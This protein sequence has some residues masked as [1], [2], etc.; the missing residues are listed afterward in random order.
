VLTDSEL[1]TAGEAGIAVWAGR[2]VLDAQSPVDDETLA[3][4]AERCAGP[5]PAP[6][7]DLWRV[8]FGGRLD[9]QLD[10]PVSL[11]ELFYP[12]SDGYRDLWGW[13]DHETELAAEHQPDWPGRLTHLPIGGFE[14]LD[15]VYLQ[16]AAGP[17]HGGVVYWQ[18]GLPPG[19]ELTADDRAGLLADSLTSLFDRLAL[20]QDPWEVDEADTGDAM[21]DAIDSL[22]E[23]SDPH[24]RS[25]AGKLRRMVRDTV[26]DWRGAL[27]AGTLVAQRRLRR[28]ALD[29]AASAGD[30]VLLDRLVALGCDPAE[31]VRNGLTPIDLA[32]LAG[33]TGTARHLLAKG[34]PV[35]NALR[36]GAHAVDLPLAR[37]LLDRGAAVDAS[38]VQRATGNPDAAVVRLL[39]HAV[40]SS[41]DLAPHFRMLAAAADAAAGRAQAAGH[42]ETA[43]REARRAEIF[44]EIAATMRG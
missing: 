39:A 4:V 9:Y 33:A 25:A 1:L 22:A 36:V 31:E 35:A 10:S 40:P 3:A 26:L 13:I 38:A 18:Q 7:V 44:R 34:V 30:L 20:E 32:L 43:A 41:P 17:G 8:T 2:L 5:L 6:L 28:L 11:A 37:D 21:R 12:D 29:H 15:R 27:Q 16:T 24:A 42:S 19:W 14:Y 23:S